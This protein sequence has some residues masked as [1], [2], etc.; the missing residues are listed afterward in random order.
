MK[1][2]KSKENKE[3]KE[4]SSRVKSFICQLSL[5]CSYNFMQTIQFDKAD[6]N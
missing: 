2:F 1:N 5:F 6:L 4:N 3:N